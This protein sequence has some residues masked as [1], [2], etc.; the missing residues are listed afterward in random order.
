MDTKKTV[1][2]GIAAIPQQHI[3]S[4][5]ALDPV[6]RGVLNRLDAM[7]QSGELE[8]AARDFAGTGRAANGNGGGQ[9]EEIPFLPEYRT[10]TVGDVEYELRSPVIKQEKQILALLSESQQKLG[11]IK[12]DGGNIK[13]SL[14]QTAQAAFSLENLVGVLGD[15]IAQFFA[16]IVTPKGMAVKDKKLDEI[17][18][19]LED[20]LSLTQQ[21]EMLKDFFGYAQYA[22]TLLAPQIESMADSIIKAV[23]RSLS[24]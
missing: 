12:I 23:K 14:K 4:L 2:E 5:D 17:A 22:G 15:G 16:I 1:L 9:P 8:Q 21:A 3:V 13:K 11:P 7:E 20:N 6:A 10:W 24:R 18:L 19:H